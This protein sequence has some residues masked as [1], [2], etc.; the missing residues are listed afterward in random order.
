MKHK[1]KSFSNPA[2]KV[3]IQMVMLIKM[4]SSTTLPW[5]LKNRKNTEN[6]QIQSLPKKKK[7]KP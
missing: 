4:S 5:A 7:K 6:T 3:T 1:C 2:N